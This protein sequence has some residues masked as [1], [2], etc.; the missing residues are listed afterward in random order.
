M[1]GG[2][3]K[4]W[5]GAWTSVG[6]AR[7][8]AEAAACAEKMGVRQAPG[9]PCHGEGGEQPGRDL[10]HHQRAMSSAHEAHERG[11]SPPPTRAASPALAHVSWGGRDPCRGPHTGVGFEFSLKTALSQESQSP[12][13]CLC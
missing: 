8:H 2:T 13:L 1:M 6:C 9:S 4:W 10:S 12:G 3:L 11:I 7:R 5:Y